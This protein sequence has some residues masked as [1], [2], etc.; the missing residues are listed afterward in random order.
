MAI[1]A[2]RTHLDA[3][4]S[5]PWS[6]RI[7]PRSSSA[8]PSVSTWSFS[9]LPRVPAHWGFR[10]RTYLRH[11][12][13]RARALLGAQ[14]PGALAWAELALLAAPAARPA[15]GRVTECRSTTISSNFVNKQ[16]E[17]LIASDNFYGRKLKGGGHH[18]AGLRRG[19]RQ[20]PFSQKPEDLPGRR[21]SA[22]ACRR[23]PR[24]NRSSASIPAR[25]P[26]VPRH[27]FPTPAKDV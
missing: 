1:S 19:L 15:D 27:R 14:R 23:I 4:A 10:R 17:R 24:E 25:V 21:T 11:P 12:R 18:P 8:R 2:R 22:R 13:A 20:A 16:I 9:A 26:Q 6:M 7:A 3:S 5:S